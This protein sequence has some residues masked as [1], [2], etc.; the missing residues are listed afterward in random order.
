MAAALL[1]LLALLVGAH[2]LARGSVGRVGVDSAESAPVTS[3]WH[4]PHLKLIDAF[5]PGTIFYQ[6]SALGEAAPD[7]DAPP[8]GAGSLRLAI[9]GVDGQLNV[10]AELGADLDLSGENLVIWLRV[11]D[12]ASLAYVALYVGNDDLESYAAYLVSIGDP[13]PS[14][15]LARGGEWHAVSVNLA[16]PYQTVGRPDL[17]RIDALQLSVA[18]SGAGEAVV[19]V[20][21]LASF[22]RAARGAVTLMFDDARDGVS[23]AVPVLQHLGLPASI[24][25]ITGFLD[26]P[27]FMSVA[28]LV[29][30]ESYLHW[31]TVAHHTSEVPLDHSFDAYDV[32]ALASEFEALTDALRGLTP[33]AGWRHLAYPNGRI[34]E[35]A[36]ETV[37]RYFTSGRTTVNQLGLETWPP[38]DQYRLRAMSVLATDPPESLIDLIDRAAASGGWLILTFHQIVEGAPEFPTQYRLDDFRRVVEHLAGVDV[39]VLL[40]SDRWP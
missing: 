34:D 14:M 23:L 22:P 7:S 25:V 40:L 13:D 11:E 16:D 31:E 33:S 5:E 9:A 37:R 39:D 27:G 6:Q 4:D 35:R 30:L 21:G 19:N 20:H 18:A 28:E 36:L 1:A 10:R 8:G 17:T 24:A 29:A 38:G 3:A 32:E 26:R 15:L 2:A 12:P